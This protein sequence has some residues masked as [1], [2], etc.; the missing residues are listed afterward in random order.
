M[1]TNFSYRPN[2]PDFGIYAHWPTPG[3][4]WIHPHDVSVALRLIPSRRVFE[5][6]R[7]DG[8]Y[9]HLRYGVQRLRV[10]PSSWTGV[11]AVDVRVGDCVELLSDFGRFEPGIATVKEVF[12]SASGEKFEF[13]VRRGTMVLPTRFSREQ[14]RLLTRR[15]RLRTG[16]FDHQ[17]PK[18]IPPPDAEL[19]DVGELG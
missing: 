18:F 11:S 3:Y 13:V 2:L 15:Y 8:T 1:E 16:Y 6:S 17:L 10:R 7:F 5:R 4:S 14:F 19:L 9:Y 12:A